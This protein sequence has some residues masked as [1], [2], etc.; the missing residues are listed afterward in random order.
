M[1]VPPDIRAFMLAEDPD[2]DLRLAAVAAFEKEL[3]V[4]EAA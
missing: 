4:L 1:P 2:E 3:R